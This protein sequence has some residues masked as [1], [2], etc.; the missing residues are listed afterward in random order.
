MD[1]SG[2]SGVRR[3]GRDGHSPL[4]GLED[5]VPLQAG[6]VL[7]DGGVQPLTCL[8]V[9]L[10]P[11]HRRLVV[12]PEVGLRESVSRS[13][14]SNSASP[15]TVARQ[16]PLSM[17][18]SR[19]EYCSGLPFP[20]PGEL[21]CPGIAPTSPAL[22][23]DSLPSEPRGRHNI[24]LGWRLRL[25]Q[26]GA[27][28]GPHP[29][30]HL[31]PRP[32]LTAP[33]AST[34]QRRSMDCT[35][36]WL[37]SGQALSTSRFT[38][39]SSSRR[40]RRQ[41]R[42]LRAVLHS[43]MSCGQAAGLSAPGIAGGPLWELPGPGPA[44]TPISQA[45]K[46]RLGEA[47]ETGH[48]PVSGPPPLVYAQCPPPPPD[49]ERGLTRGA[50]GLEGQEGAQHA[51]VFRTGDDFVGTG[52]EDGVVTISGGGVRCGN[53]GPKPGPEVLNTHRGWTGG[54]QTWRPT[55]ISWGFGENKY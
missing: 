35:C 16:A 5:G 18:S 42:K 25:H 22:Q 37:S 50:E 31:C 6:D 13:V 30:A 53:N 7:A 47:A 40:R 34:N 32:T 20:P 17:G 43:R 54:S 19:Q 23:A 24:G 28:V 1:S 46:L 33:S 3:G 26:Q 21:P 14:V 15:W 44:I 48:R 36:M 52:Q 2:R 39:P 27:P 55:R 45:G 8:P 29:R 10:Q 4:D 9:L 38:W 49:P 41:Y 51:G 11:P 12:V